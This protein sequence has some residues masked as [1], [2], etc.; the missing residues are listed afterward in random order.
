MTRRRLL[1]IELLGWPYRA[2]SLTACALYAAA[3]WCERRASG[4]SALRWRLLG[5]DVRRRK[6]CSNSP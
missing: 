6:R 1:A 3:G 5:V 2:F 4:I